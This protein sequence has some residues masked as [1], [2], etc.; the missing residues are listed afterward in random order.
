MEVLSKRN[1]EENDEN[2]TAE[3]IVAMKLIRAHKIRN[4]KDLSQLHAKNRSRNKLENDNANEK[5]TEQTE[6][7]GDQDV[8]MLKNKA[9]RKHNEHS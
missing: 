2:M 4:I 5:P 3:Q 7:D 6:M 9:V 8:S 1:E